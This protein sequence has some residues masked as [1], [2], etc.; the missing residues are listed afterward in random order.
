MRGRIK[1]NA[2][3]LTLEQGKTWRSPKP[4]GSAPSRRLSGMAVKQWSTRDAIGL[5]RV[6]EYESDWKIPAG[7]ITT[8]DADLIS[9]LAAGGEIE[10]HLVLTP[11][12]L[13]PAQSYNV[14]VGFEGV[15]VAG[16][17]RSGVWSSRFLGPGN[18][19]ARR[20]IRRGRGHGCAARHKS[21]KSKTQSARLQDSRHEFAYHHTAADTFDKVRIDELRQDLEVVS[22]L[23]YALAQADGN[24]T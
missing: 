17:D 11:R 6:T 9:A 21:D 15:A 14:I 2:E 19:S 8:E 10:M 12:D 18:G 4:N 16:A 24:G 1:E 5:H 23:V 20:C 7:A 22:S 3:L 13:P